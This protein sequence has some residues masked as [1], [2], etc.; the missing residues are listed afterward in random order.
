[1]KDLV[2]KLCLSLSDDEIAGAITAIVEH[3][4]EHPSNLENLKVEL[5]AALGKN[6]RYIAC[7]YTIMKELDFI[8]PRSSQ[9]KLPLYVFRGDKKN[10]F[11]VVAQGG[12]IAYGTSKNIVSHKFFT[13]ESLY[14][15][16]SKDLS[17]A[18]EFAHSH[19]AN[20]IYKIKSDNGIC[21]ND[22]LAPVELHQDEEEVIFPHRVPTSQIEGVAIV[23]DLNSLATKF[24]PL[25]AVQ[26]IK[27]AM[28]DLGI[29]K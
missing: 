6:G 21:T 24:F 23:A 16:T 11:E 5:I 12:F 1:M 14:V 28:R 26:E 29:S 13:S 2:N 9:S 7:L 8:P 17:I 22:F 15:S 18:L 19:N 10:P 25:D 3:L 20:W 27:D 4:N